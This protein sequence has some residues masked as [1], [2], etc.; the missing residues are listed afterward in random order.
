[1]PKSVVLCLDIRFQLGQLVTVA[2]DVD[3]L[4]VLQEGH[5]GFHANMADI[6][7]KKGR[8]HRITEKGDVRVQYPGHPPQDYRW[9]INPAAL[10]VLHGHAV[11]DSV[12][13]TADRR[14]VERFHQNA[15][16]LDGVLGCAGTVSQVNSGQLPYDLK[17]Y[18]TLRFISGSAAFYAVLVL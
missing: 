4:R 17:T 18:S 5:G 16:A 14:L 11:G 13:L 7:G 8:V 6:V 2:V 1:M 12:T 9:A 15:A 10:R 3:S